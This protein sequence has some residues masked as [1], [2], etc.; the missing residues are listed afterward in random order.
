MT[1]CNDFEGAF[2]VCCAS[3][4]RLK[5]TST[6]LIKTVMAPETSILSATSNVTYFLIKK[7]HINV[8]L[9]V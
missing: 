7:K 8:I 1:D 6:L 3:G 5:E 9:K 4:P 2:M